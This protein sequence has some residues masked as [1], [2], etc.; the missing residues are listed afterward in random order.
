[1]KRIIAFLLAA[2]MLLSMSACQ[3]S[4]PGVAKTDPDKM[5]AEMGQAYSDYEGI[6]VQIDSAVWNGSEFVLNVNWVNKTSYEAAFGASYAI[7]RKDGDNWV[8]CATTDEL[9]F[10]SIAYLLNAGQTRK[11]AYHVSRMFDVTKAGTYRFRSEFSVSDGTDGAGQQTVWAEFTFGTDRDENQNK[12]KEPVEYGVQH[13]RT[14]GYQDGAK[15]PQVVVIRSME[16]LNGYY[17]TNKDT[18]SLGRRAEVSADSTIGFLDACD[19]YD[20]AYFEKGYLVFVLLEEGSG[21]IRHEVTDCT[22]SSDG[23]LGIYIDTISPEVGTCDMAQWH[24]I[25]EMNNAIKVKDESSVQIYLDGRLTFDKG[26]VVSQTIGMQS[27]N[28]VVLRKPPA[29]KMLY[30]NGSIPLSAAGYHWMYPNGDEKMEAAKADYAH[31]LDCKGLLE[32]ISVKGH[33]VKLDF[34]DAPDSITVRCWPDTK[35]NQNNAVA[36]T[37]IC[38]GNT[39]DLIKGGYIY[40]IT[41][42]WNESEGEHHGTVNYYI[43]IFSSAE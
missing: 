18:Y 6:E 4:N 31:P 40:E 34:E 3:P 15:F 30:E 10:I 7:E 8:S 29:A 9:V 5:G 37:V 42:K 36:E 41:A 2:I 33:Y 26:S 32:P 27:Q 16:E 22:I 19:K 23:E 39:F 12:T 35:W 1:M 28:P 20:A 14:D 38:Q 17:D 13:I 24:I 25:L 21:S 43:Y 11:E